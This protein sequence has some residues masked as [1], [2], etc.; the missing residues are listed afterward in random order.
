MYNSFKIKKDSK[1]KQDATTNNKSERITLDF[2]ESELEKI[3]KLRIDM[4][5][6]INNSTQLEYV[7]KFLDTNFIKESKSM[8]LSKERCIKFYVGLFHR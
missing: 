7:S 4:C 2:I 1:S 3:F 5:R 8:L 6:L